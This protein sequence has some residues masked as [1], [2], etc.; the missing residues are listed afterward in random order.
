[1][2]PMS[3]GEMLTASGGARPRQD[4][5]L[6]VAVDGSAASLMAIDWAAREAGSLGLV[7]RLVHVV[8]WPYVGPGADAADAAALS[9]EVLAEGAA[10][11]RGAA[12]PLDVVTESCRG[13]LGPTL[14]EKSRFAHTVVLGHRDMTGFAGMVLGSVSVAVAT[15][16]DGPVVV[17]PQAPP[18]ALRPVRPLVV[19]G[20]DG[21]ESSAAAVTYAFEYAARHGY[22]LEA[23]SAGSPASGD[24]HPDRVVRDVA[25]TVPGVPWR[26]RR[27][28]GAPVES[29]TGVAAEAALLVVG[30]R[31]RVDETSPLL[32]SVSRGAIFLS[33]CPVAVV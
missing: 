29:L 10:R 12:G 11:A 1:V 24:D 19:V 2:T 23:V 4:D 9:A 22:G 26:A 6:V 30:C 8:G 7:L 25:R 31:T 14:L 15:H 18:A 17:V 13:R 20:V 16:A 3:A 32:G 33:R 28:I 27:T 5:E 21:T